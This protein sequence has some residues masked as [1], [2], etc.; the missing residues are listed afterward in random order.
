MLYLR[1]LIKYF[2]L[3]LTGFYINQGFQIRQG[4]QYIRVLNMS[5]LIKKTLH[6]IDVSQGSD[7]SSHML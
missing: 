3:Y 6:R 7:Y 1:V 5:G 2:I 4:S